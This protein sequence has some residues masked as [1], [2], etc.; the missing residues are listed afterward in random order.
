MQRN[1][2]DT[3]KV[4]F[5]LSTD[6]FS[7]C[8]ALLGLRRYLDEKSIEEVKLIARTV[9]SS[10]FSTSSNYY[11]TDLSDARIKSS[12]DIFIS[13]SK[14][15]L[16][17]S[18]FQSLSEIVNQIRG[19][20]PLSDNERW[21]IRN[22]FLSEVGCG[23]KGD[24]NGLI[25]EDLRKNIE[26]ITTKFSDI[27]APELFRSR[28]DL[29]LANKFDETPNFLINYAEFSFFSNVFFDFISTEISD[30]KLSKNNIDLIGDW[31]SL[32]IS[33]L[34]VYTDGP[35]ISK[36]LHLCAEERSKL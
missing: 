11:E 19:N 27:S 22:Y 14:A 3:D 16:G 15:T 28:W 6:W 36:A 21:A 24:D 35:I 34:G 32:G 4:I 13:K 26:S 8:V 33:S 10:I 18:A 23:F 2:D 9:S 31:I 7:A 25:D 20:H 30:R 5:L 1:Y 17:S 12:Y 29:S